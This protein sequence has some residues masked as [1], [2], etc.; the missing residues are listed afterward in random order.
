MSSLVELIE[1]IYNKLKDNKEGKVA[2]Y[3]PQL[4]K[5]NPELIR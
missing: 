1:T 3:I 4:G 5:V 2:D